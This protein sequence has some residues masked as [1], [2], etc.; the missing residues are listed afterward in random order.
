MWLA[1]SHSWLLST[2]Q[3]QRKM[4]M[5][6][7]HVWLLLVC[8]WCSCLGKAAAKNCSYEASTDTV[9]CSLTTLSADENGS[10]GSSSSYTPLATRA[11]ALRVTCTNSQVESFLRG[12]HFGPGLKRLQELSI[13]RCKVRRVP[14]GAFEGLTGLTVLNLRS[15]NVKVSLELEKEALRGIGS[16]RELDLSENNLW[17]V[18]H[19]IFCGLKSLQRL[20]VS[21]NFLQ[22]N[23]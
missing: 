1:A 6:K 20:N 2:Q 18:P 16:L 21:R 13:E 14:A 17:T 22:V 7:P 15:G 9:R 12:A 19:G 10:S 11:A 4:L 3:L 5:C 23:L 8:L